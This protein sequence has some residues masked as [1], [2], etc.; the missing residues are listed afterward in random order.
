M[1]NDTMG[2]TAGLQLRGGGLMADGPSIL[3]T[4]P[5][6]QRHAPHT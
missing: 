2:A 6:F 4:S 3:R 1:S 5:Q